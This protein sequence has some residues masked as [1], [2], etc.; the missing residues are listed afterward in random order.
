M[1]PKQKQANEQEQLTW[2]IPG[3]SDDTK[4]EQNDGVGF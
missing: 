1:L 3:Q 2:I 4:S